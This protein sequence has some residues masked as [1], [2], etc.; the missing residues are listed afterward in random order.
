M[1]SE[2]KIVCHPS[3]TLVAG[4]P[5]GLAP[6]EPATDELPAWY[7]GEKVSIRLARTEVTTSWLQ[8][9]QYT[10]GELRQCT[11]RVCWYTFVAAE[12]LLPPRASRTESTVF[13]EAC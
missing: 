2:V 7:A 1:L 13:V 5:L 8:E 11:S 12:S 6:T 10:I 3:A 4:L 9:L